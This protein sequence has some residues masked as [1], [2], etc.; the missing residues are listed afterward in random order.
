MF[1]RK[2]EKW[3][4]KE[5]DVSESLMSCVFL[6]IKFFKWVFL[7]DSVCDDK[8]E[9]KGPWKKVTSF[10]GQALECCQSLRYR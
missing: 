8:W 3:K 2:G 7:L 1:V 6:V 9:L 10:Y 4:G 5:C